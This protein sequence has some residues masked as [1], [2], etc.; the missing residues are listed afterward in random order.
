MMAGDRR[1]A[2][3]FLIRGDPAG[4][5]LAQTA[6]DPGLHGFGLLVF[7]EGQGT[8]IRQIYGF[9]RARSIQ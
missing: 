8:G 1:G 9:W 3:V 2:E 4:K 5:G 6:R 7:P